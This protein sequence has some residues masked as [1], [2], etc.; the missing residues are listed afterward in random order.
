MSRQPGQRD[1]E[2]R[3]KE[4]ECV[5]CGRHFQRNVKANKQRWCGD[6]V[7]V[8]YAE[9]DAAYYQRTKATLRAKRRA[10]A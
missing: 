5:R 3:Y 2:S 1:T 9:R 10:S 7:K 8:R 4:Q 6:C